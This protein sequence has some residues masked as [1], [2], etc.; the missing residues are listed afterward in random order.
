MALGY[1]SNVQRKLFIF[2]LFKSA[3][4]Q[5]VALCL[6][7]IMQYTMVVFSIDAVLDSLVWFC[8]MTKL[9]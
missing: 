7:T 4:F 8:S 9:V 6:F 2:F 1:D 3:I 5:S